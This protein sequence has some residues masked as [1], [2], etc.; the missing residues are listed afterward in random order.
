MLLEVRFELSQ[1]EHCA[2]CAKGSAAVRVLVGTPGAR[3]I[4]DECLGLCRD[5]IREE[6][7]PEEPKE[8]PEHA[9]KER[10]ERAAKYVE[11]FKELVRSLESPEAKADWLRRHRCTFCDAARAEVAKLVVGPGVVIC[12]RCVDLATTV[13]NQ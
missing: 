5:I 11:R 6:V 12:D 3:A 13:V 2:F 4:C 9:R 1:T 8:V 7:A 10:E